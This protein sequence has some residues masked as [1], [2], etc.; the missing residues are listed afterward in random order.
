MGSMKAT[1]P[2]AASTRS[3]RA[4]FLISVMACFTRWMAGCNSIRTHDGGSAP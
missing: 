3:V 1:A 4:T 2:S